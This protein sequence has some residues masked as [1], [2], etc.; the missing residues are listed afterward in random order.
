MKKSNF[1]NNNNKQ[2]NRSKR[3]K[4]ILK[5]ERSFLHPLDSFIL[6]SKVIN[7]SKIM[8]KQSMNNKIQIS[9]KWDKLDVFARKKRESSK[10]YG[11][12]NEIKNVV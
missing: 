2:I 1:A 6:K 4:P 3:E 9:E 7:S 11:T 8:R 5:L 10:K 12:Q